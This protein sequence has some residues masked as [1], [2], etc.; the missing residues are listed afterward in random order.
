M[1]TSLDSN[2]PP[3]A[4]CLILFLCR[5]N[6]SDTHAFVNG[7]LGS[8]FHGYSAI[9][10]CDDRFNGDG[11]PFAGTY[12]LALIAI[13]VGS[14]LLAGLLQWAFLADIAS[15]AAYASVVLLVLAIV[16]AIVWSIVQPPRL[17]CGS[18]PS[19]YQSQ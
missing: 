18:P 2:L 9:C 12:I 11:F 17:C 8:H 16:S 13:Y 19:E 6:G 1:G 7:N 5:R 14:F 4:P 3:W 10:Y 15:R